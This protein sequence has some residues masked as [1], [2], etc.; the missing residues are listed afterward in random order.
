LG[1]CNE[2]VREEL[3]AV[4]YTDSAVAG[5]SYLPL[6][7]CFHVVGTFFS[8]LTYFANNFFAVIQFSYCIFVIIIM[9]MIMIMMSYLFFLLFN[10]QV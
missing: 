5:A 1:T 6:F 9:I 7:L 10:K 3:K 4:L 8:P 2:E